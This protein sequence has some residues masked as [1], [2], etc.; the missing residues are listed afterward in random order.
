MFSQPL[1]NSPQAQLEKL[2]LDFKGEYKETFGKIEDLVKLG[3]NLNKKNAQGQTAAFL[4]LT[5]KDPQTQPPGPA[6]YIQGIF[7]LGGDPRILTDDD[8][9]VFSEAAGMYLQAMWR[10]YT[11]I[12]PFE[13]EWG[14]TFD[15]QWTMQ[16][17]NAKNGG[18]IPL[19]KKE[20]EKIYPD[21]IQAIQ[22]DVLPLLEQEK[23]RLENEY[24][25]EG[26]F[27]CGINRADERFN[28][29]WSMIAHINS[30]ISTNGLTK[31]DC[32]TGMLKIIDKRLTDS[33]LDK[34]AGWARTFA[35]LLLNAVM[36]VFA[37]VKKLVTDSWF[38]SLTGRTHELG[39]RVRDQIANGDNPRPKGPGN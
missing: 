25:E 19:L 32:K 12:D 3:A 21:Y 27:I 23:K 6:A 39:Q 10:D 28:A 38:Y 24:P 35:R 4:F 7:E 36:L 5:Y 1:P 37:P 34:Y 15:P 18:I 29:I 14:D 30:L 22:N 20:N 31:N 33:S 13:A 8:K 17:L 2:A 26:G 9:N 16:Q 11:G